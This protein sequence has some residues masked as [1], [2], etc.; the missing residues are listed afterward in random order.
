MIAEKA[1]AEDLVNEA[2]RLKNDAIL[3]SVTAYCLEID[4]VDLIRS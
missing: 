2:I 1:P 4:R 3:E